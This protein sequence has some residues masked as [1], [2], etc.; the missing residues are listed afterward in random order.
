VT[1][2]TVPSRISSSSSR[3]PAVLTPS[4]RVSS[5]LALTRSG[6]GISA[7]RSV[8]NA[9]S[10]YVCLPSCLLFAKSQPLA[11]SLHVGSS[12]RPWA[13]SSSLELAGA[14]AGPSIEYTSPRIFS[15]AKSNTSCRARMAPSSCRTPRGNGTSTQASLVWTGEPRAMHVC[16][17]RTQPLAGNRRATLR[18][19]EAPNCT[20]TQPLAGNRRATPLL[21]S[22]RLVRT[23]R[24]RAGYVEETKIRIRNQSL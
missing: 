16:S 21:R 14:L 9:Q 22:P 18:N 4:V 2:V 11:G 10:S 13:S 3:N 17:A 24:C 8:A 20:G 12:A 15:S 1:S 19:P 7:Q 23:V 5:A 6:G